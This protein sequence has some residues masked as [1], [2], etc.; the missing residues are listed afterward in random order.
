MSIFLALIGPLWARILGI[1]VKIGLPAAFSF[2]T[3]LAPILTGLGQLVGAI[4]T[5]IGEILAALSKSAEG[6]VALFLMAALA[7][8]LYL[9]FH[10]I[11]EG[12]A[13]E[14]AKIAAAHK[15]CPAVRTERRSR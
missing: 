9:R 5:A 3:P 12:K 8:F 4:V 11:E 2:L 6:R 15:P 14:K 1:L 7:G 10:Y 13:I